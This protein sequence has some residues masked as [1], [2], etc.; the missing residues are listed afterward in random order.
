MSRLSRYA[1]VLGL[2]L[3]CAG[4]PAAA[5]SQTKT[6]KKTATSSVS[7]RIT[8]HGKGASGIVVGIRSSDFSQR[9]LP[10]LKATTDQD[11]NY[12]ITNIP[13]GNYQV[14]PMAP[15]YVVADLV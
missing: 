2:A 6:Q 3:T 15:S 1:I 7:G 13:P 12:Q 4:F 10:A 5:S 11:G 9:P 14:W 8:I